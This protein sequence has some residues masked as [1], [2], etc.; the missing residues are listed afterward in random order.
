TLSPPAEVMKLR[1]S[2]VRDR[3]GNAKHVRRVPSGGEPDGLRKDRSSSGPCN[4]MKRLVPPVVGW[5]TQTINRRGIVHELR[6]FFFHRH[7]ANQIV[8]P[9]FHRS[10]RVAVKG[11]LLRR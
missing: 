4:P 5:Y 10:V 8:H 1:P 6:D 11:G 3:S 7:P 2:L 9:S